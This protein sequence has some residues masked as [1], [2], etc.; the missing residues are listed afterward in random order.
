[1]VVANKGEQWPIRAKTCRWLYA[2][3]CTATSCFLL[4]P[5]LIAR[6]GHGKNH[7]FRMVSC[8]IS[9]APPLAWWLAHA[10][11]HTKTRATFKLASWPCCFRR[12]IS[13]GRT[14]EL[15]WRRSVE[16]F[17]SPICEHIAK[18]LSRVTMPPRGSCGEPSPPIIGE[19]TEWEGCSGECL[20]SFPELAGKAWKICSTTLHLDTLGAKIRGSQPLILSVPDFSGRNPF[21]YKTKVL[22]RNHRWVP[23]LTTQSNIQRSL[24]AHVPSI[25]ESF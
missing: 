1:M 23:V 9:R 25:W 13:V 14:V 7:Q 18:K 21:V 5:A 11:T 12:S 6:V 24:P 2:L 8:E 16:R 20:G 22:V 10:H 3:Y 17:N 15:C 19:W 4:L